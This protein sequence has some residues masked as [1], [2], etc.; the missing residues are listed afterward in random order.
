ME[1]TN[2]KVDIN[3]Y[4]LCK[5][6]NDNIEFKGFNGEKLNINISKI[7]NNFKDS[8]VYRFKK[9]KDEGNE[10]FFIKNLSTFEQTDGIQLSNDNSVFNEF[11]PYSIIGKVIL[12]EDDKIYLLTPYLNKIIIISNIGK[13]FQNIHYYQYIYI[14]YIRFKLK[15]ENIIYF[16]LTD[17]T[18]VKIIENNIIE[19]NKINSKV[20]I[21]LKI[22]DFF[23]ENDKIQIKNIG[24]QLEEKN[25]KIIELNK[26]IIYF[27][28]ETNE[29]EYDYFPQKIYL[30]D[31]YDSFPHILKFFVYKGFF[32]EANLFI[33]NK[34]GLAYEF[35]YFSLDNKLPNEIEIIQKQNKKLKVKNFHS[36]NSQTRKS[37]IFI[38]L[39]PQN[40]IDLG[41]DASF[42]TIYLCNSKEIKLYGNFCLDSIKIIKK[43]DYHFNPIVKILIYEIYNDFNSNLTIAN[44]KQK[45]IYF[46]KI[47]NEKLK[48]EFKQNFHLFNY[49]NEK[50]TLN[51]F[52]SLCLWNLFYYI[53]ENNGDNNCILDYINLYKK[54]LDKKELN[55]VDKSLIL[56]SFVNRIFESKIVFKS[57]KLFFYDELDN[58][59][60]YKMAYNFQFEIIEKLK[61]QSCLFLPFLFIDS[62]NMNCIYNKDYNFKK[63]YLS[64]YSLSMLPLEI[65]KAYLKRKIKNYFFILEKGEN[66]DR[67][68]Y[69]SIHKFNFVVTYNENIILKNSKI[70]NIYDCGKLCYIEDKKNLAFIINLENLC[71]NFSHNKEEIINNEIYP[72][73]FFNNNYQLSKIYHYDKDNYRENGRLLE[74]F[75]AEKSLINEMKKTQYEMGKFLD[76]KYFI[77]KNFNGLIEEF[78][79]IFSS[80][81]NKSNS[82]SKE[83]IDNDDIINVNTYKE[84]KDEELQKDDQKD[85][86]KEKID[87]QIDDDDVIYL[88][89]H[90]TYILTAETI[91]ELM[92][93]VDDMKNKKIIKS[94]DAIE[95]NNSTTNY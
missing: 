54:I 58:D 22:L 27:I 5:I 52:N 55:Y 3:H 16:T 38:N 24:I 1:A 66:D 41:Y 92:K 40:N 49:P 47:I 20:C 70:R 12:I 31:I 91:E 34:L 86:T 53:N 8:F 79:I 81:Q 69:S 88:S 35:L 51:Y 67:K 68:Y 10:L 73:L 59:N 76:V 60:P 74:V 72:T 63:G 77:D 42:L 62:Y 50:Y 82:D 21:K 64:A 57:P 17:F 37:I 56:I 19:L 75:I 93:K 7:D 36:F 15:D 18:S 83:S 14:Y 80:Q 84:I 85:K 6:K 23:E 61:E 25:I 71:Q 32:N 65:I 87:E 90:N 78:K 26:E 44:L 2:K 4:F 30:Y 28:Y 33:R 39:P 43:N 9:L 48:K 89:K 11:E 46:N 94:E 13:F 45:Y 29:N 95:D